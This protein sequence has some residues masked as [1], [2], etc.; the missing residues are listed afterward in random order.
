MT[1]P[2]EATSIPSASVVQDFPLVQTRPPKAFRPTSVRPPRRDRE[3]FGQYTARLREPGYREFITE[4][5]LVVVEGFNDVIGLDNLG[6]PALGIMFN[7]MTEAQ[8][9]KITRWAR[10][11]VCGRVT[12]MFD[13]EQ[14]GSDGAKEALWYFAQQ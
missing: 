4:H 6:A 10:Q 1:H 9:E 2:S 13:C 8:G 11:L 5:G 12:L 14:T 7:R 3:L